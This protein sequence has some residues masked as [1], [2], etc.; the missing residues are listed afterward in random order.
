ML[1]IVVANI[2]KGAGS[3]HVMAVQNK[4]LTSR[5]RRR[6]ILIRRRARLKMGSLS[7]YAQE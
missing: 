5:R 3:S 2:K 6:A 7:L 1:K 4:T